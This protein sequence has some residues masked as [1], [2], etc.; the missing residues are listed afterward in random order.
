MILATKIHFQY[1][2]PAHPSEQDIQSI[3][4]S[5]EELEGFYLKE[6][7]YDMIL[8]GEIIRV[9]IYPYPILEEMTSS[10]GEKYVRSMPNESR[11]DNLLN[12]PR[13]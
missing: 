1:G 12:L 6:Q 9:N 5:G 10:K 4:L 2:C 11:H 7:V 8:Q 3:Y 13:A